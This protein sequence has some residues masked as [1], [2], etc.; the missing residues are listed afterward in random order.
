MHDL[1][2]YYGALV[3]SGAAPPPDPIHS[4]LHYYTSSRQG[5]PQGPHNRTPNHSATSNTHS[6]SSL[7]A[8]MHDRIQSL[9]Y[10]MLHR[11]RE[12]GPS[13]LIPTRT[14]PHMLII[15]VHYN[16]QPVP[17]A[18]LAAFLPLYLS[19]RP[20]AYQQHQPCARVPPAGRDPYEHTRLQPVPASHLWPAPFSSCLE[21]LYGTCMAEAAPA[22]ATL[23][24][25]CT[26]THRHKRAP[27]G[28][29]YRLCP[30]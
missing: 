4:P 18:D 24:A 22:G 5:P 30:K 7:G 1:I 16:Q 13:P 23:R 26:H 12:A 10:A 14:L 27:T 8:R 29:P 28:L 3:P 20:H 11:Y 2:Q 9:P 6:N 15:L 25:A 21:V 17:P 19:S